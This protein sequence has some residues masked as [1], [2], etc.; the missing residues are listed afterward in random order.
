MQTAPVNPADM[1]VQDLGTYTAQERDAVCGIYRVY[2]I[3]GMGP[4]SSGATTVFAI[5]K[6]LE[7]FDLA[8]IGPDDPV[9][10]HLFAE[11]QRLAY[12]DRERYL[13]DADFVQ[14]PVQGL[15]DADYLARRGALIDTGT[16]MA[17]GRARARRRLALAFATQ[18]EPARTRHLPFRRHRR[19]GNVVSYTSTDRGGVRI[20]PVRAA[21]TSTTN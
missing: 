5:L 18:P 14:V 3:C 21:S 16:T 9:G 12:A 7:R 19:D 20:G 4:P 15:I 2:R 11:S 17:S 8:A 1:T 13:A 10:W 6:Q